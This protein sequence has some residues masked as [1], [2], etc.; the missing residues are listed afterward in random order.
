MSVKDNGNL[1]PDGAYWS[2]T[3]SFPRVGQSA[4]EEPPGLFAAAAPYRPSK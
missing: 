4:L 2:W 1:R 3:P